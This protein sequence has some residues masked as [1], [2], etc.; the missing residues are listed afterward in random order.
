MAERGEM[1][2]RK[3]SNNKEWGSTQSDLSFAKSLMIF[4]E[5]EYIKFYQNVKDQTRC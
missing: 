2:I 3:R 1:I 4:Y 5:T